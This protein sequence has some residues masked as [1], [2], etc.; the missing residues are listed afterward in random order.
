MTKHRSSGTRSNAEVE[1]RQQHHVPKDSEMAPSCL[2]CGQDFSSGVSHEESSG[3]SATACNCISAQV[4][5]S[6]PLDLDLSLRQPAAATRLVFCFGSASPDAALNELRPWLVHGSMLR[7]ARQ[8]DTQLIWRCVFSWVCELCM[9]CLLT[10]TGVS[11]CAFSAA[12]THS[13]RQLGTLLSFFEACKLRSHVATTFWKEASAA[14][15]LP[16]CRPGKGQLQ[17]QQESAMARN[18]LRGGAVDSHEL[19]F[20]RLQKVIAAEACQE[21]EAWTRSHALSSLVLYRRRGL[22][23]SLFM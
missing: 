1:P 11:A 4:L 16:L 15:A 19:G 3:L 21:C 12:S 23:I 20:G 10:S 14:S 22:G 7:K 5:W 6:Q 18:E 17:S 2:N 9:V 8:H 13:A